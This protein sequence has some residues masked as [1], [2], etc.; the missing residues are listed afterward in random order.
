M[1]KI[2]QDVYA[3]PR[4]SA[5]T[6]VTSNATSLSV[7][8]DFAGAESH[9]SAGALFAANICGP[10]CEGVNIFGFTVTATDSTARTITFTTVDS[11]LDNYLQGTLTLKIKASASEGDYYPIGGPQGA[12]MSGRTAPGVLLGG[13][14]AFITSNSALTGIIWWAPWGAN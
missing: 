7:P 13:G 10:K 1:G 6:L 14:F 4:G 5:Y 8:T 3:P 11:G 12:F 9:T 2:W